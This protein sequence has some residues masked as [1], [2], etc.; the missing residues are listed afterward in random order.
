MLGRIH[1][2][3]RDLV[4]S[5]GTLAF[6]AVDLRRAGPTLGRAQNDHRQAGRPRNPFVRASCQIALISAVTASRV[7]AICWWIFNGSWPSTKYG[8]VAVTF[9]QLLQF[10]FGDPRQET[11][12]GDFVTVQVED[13]E[14]CPIPFRVEEFVA[15]PPVASGRFPPLRRPRSRR[16]SDQDCQ[17]P[18]RKRATSA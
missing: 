12:I 5:P 6:F 18:R 8:F 7:S 4:R 9:E 13:G 14:H 10:V 11:G 17:R 1:V 2:A 16:R 15:V 3:H